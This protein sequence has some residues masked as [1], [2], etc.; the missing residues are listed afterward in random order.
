[1]ETLRIRLALISL[2]LL[3]S[4]CGPDAETVALAQ[5]ACAALEEVQDEPFDPTQLAAYETW[6]DANESGLNS[7]ATF[8]GS[9][10]YEQ[11]L[12]DQCGPVVEAFAVAY[13]D[14]TGTSFWHTSSA[15]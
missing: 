15:P 6:F 3:I 11:S 1:V 5:S 8:G 4:A 14:H 7:I 12:Q 10:D 2:V 13:E 9:A